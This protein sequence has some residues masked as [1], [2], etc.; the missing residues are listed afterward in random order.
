MTIFPSDRYAIGTLSNKVTIINGSYVDEL[1][2][3]EAANR[4]YRI[5]H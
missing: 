3:D 1:D 2:E 4:Q 5:R